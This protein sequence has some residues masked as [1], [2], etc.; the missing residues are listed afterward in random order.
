MNLVSIPESFRAV[1]ELTAVMRELLRKLDE[2]NK[3]LRQELRGEDAR[4]TLARQ[5]AIVAGA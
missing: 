4:S 2:T 1:T 5:G 3:G